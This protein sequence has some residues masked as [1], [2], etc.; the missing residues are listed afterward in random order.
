MEAKHILLVDDDQDDR[1]FFRE[2]I[3][4]ILPTTQIREAQD[5]VQALELLK[6]LNQ[7]L[8]DLIFLDLNMPRM[9]GITFLE[10]MNEM[11][12]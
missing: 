6:A 3:L 12:F 5:G 4:E 10:R 8:P 1:D 2:A 9:D 11:T 7:N